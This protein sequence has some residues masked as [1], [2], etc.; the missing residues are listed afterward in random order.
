MSTV[1]TSKNESNPNPF[2][3]SIQNQTQISI[4][5]Q[6]PLLTPVVSSSQSH[7]KSSCKSSQVKS[8]EKIRNK[9]VL[10]AVII[11]AT[12][13]S[14]PSTTCTYVMTHLHSSHRRDTI[15]L[16]LRSKTKTG[17][18]RARRLPTIRLDGNSAEKEAVSSVASEES[19]RRSINGRNSSRLELLEYL[20]SL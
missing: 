18:T 9:K 10:F 17:S 4:S 16:N 8:F 12:N 15:K 14:R 20:P 11:A 1:K 19:S 5:Q 2:V 13:P 3:N 7:R 6:S